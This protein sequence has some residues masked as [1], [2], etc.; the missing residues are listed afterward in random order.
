M[1]DERKQMSRTL[2]GRLARDASGNALALIAAA[3]FPLLAMVGG[4]VD[5]SR[6]YLSEARLQ[7]ACDSGVL[8][9]RKRLGSEA[10]V[11]GLLPDGVADV[12]QRF[13]NVNF[14][15]GAYGTTERSFDMELGED[16]SIAGQARVVMPTTIMHMFGFENIP[17]T[18]DCLAQLNFNNTDVMMVL[19]VTGSMAETNPGDAQSRI[20]T[21]RATIL[22]F[23]AQLQ[24][25][26]MAGTRMRYGF[27]PY[28]T[29]VNVGHLLRDEWVVD[30]WAYQSREIVETGSTTG[31]AT[32]YSAVTPVSGTQGTS[33]SETYAASF[34]EL[35]GYY[36][37]TRPPNTLKTETKKTAQMDEPFAGPPAGKRTITNYE[38]TRDGDT[39]SVRVKGS[40]CEVSRTR[41]VKYVDTYTATTEPRFG[42]STK[43]L[44]DQL[45]RDVSNWREETLGCMEERDTYEI[46]NY[47][48]V[49]LG[50]ALDLDIDRVPVQ[51]QPETQW[52][53]MYPSIIYAREMEWNG[54][55]RF[56]PK[57]VETSKD[58]IAP[59]KLG[60]AA[61]P[62]P[63]MKLTPLG[64]DELSDYLDGLNA[65]GSTYHDIGMIWGG[66]LIS[67]NGLFAAENAEGA[68][69][70]VNR[71]LIFLTDG[72]TATL[73]V[74]YSSYGMEPVDQRRWSPKSKLTLNETVERR[75]AFACSEVRKRNV[76]IWI[77]GFGTE[78]TPVMKNCAGEDHYFE[79][80][81]A[82][83]LNVTF[84]TIA[85]N[86]SQLRI[87]E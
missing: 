77:I 55:G 7:Q 52:R 70:H 5:M 14:R 82:D 18:V 58:F 36:C 75:F 13:F 17:I 34:D 21:M 10:A 54:N 61:C 4:G 38:R 72:Q 39:Y 63:A 50:R 64:E 25:A 79:A 87:L 49:N 46:G 24:Q 56:N 53:P 45:P 81:D 76:T 48:N 60:S 1:V 85:K 3:M 37:P 47:D 26:A 12:G 43:F 80:E 44:Y 84:A 40:A 83:Q 16:Y 71:H 86:M 19:D 51:G 28:S 59:A 42:S 74:S 33:I 29:N 35:K 65:T 31:K 67:P 23:H 15:D 78:L 22:S 2:L 68:N 57:K 32:Y 27:V 6:A 41:Y 62:A 11:T 69:G 73:D 9:A 20:D 66:R 30:Q 8:A